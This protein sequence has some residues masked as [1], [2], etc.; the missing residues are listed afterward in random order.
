MLVYFFF[1]WL[2]ASGS[3]QQIQDAADQGIMFVGFIQ[4]P[5][6]VRVHLSGIGDPEEPSLSLH[7]SPSSLHSSGVGQSPSPLDAASPEERDK[8]GAGSPAPLN[9]AIEE[10]VRDGGRGADEGGDVVTEEGSSIPASPSSCISDL[11]SPTHN[12]NDTKSS[13]RTNKLSSSGPARNG[14]YGHN[15]RVSMAFFNFLSCIF[16]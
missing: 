14:E 15:S 10:P 6:R 7:S 2:F 5:G 1:V 12:N 11:D 4:E 9:G 13:Q 16:S 3:L 8:F